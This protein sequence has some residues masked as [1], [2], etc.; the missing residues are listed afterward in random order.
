MTMSARV[1][2]KEGHTPILS[3]KGACK[4]FPGVQALDGVD[5]EVYPGEVVALVGENGA[6]KS[7]LMKIFS[8]AYRRDAGEILLR[9]QPF[10]PD[11]PLAARLAGISVIHQELT[12]CPDMS[13][14]EN[15]FLGREAVQRTPLVPRII[16][17]LAKREETVEADRLLREVGLAIASD[18]KMADLSVSTWQRIEIARAIS[19][20]AELIIMDEPT[21]SLTQEEVKS[22]FGIIRDLRAKGHGVVF[23]THR[24]EEIFDVADRVV[25]LRDGKFVGEL[26]IAE[27]AVPRLVSMMVG[28]EIAAPAPREQAV[29]GDVALEVR[30]LRRGSVVQ[31]VSFQVRRGEVLGV[32]GLMGAGRTEAMRLVFGAD[33]RQSGEILVEGKQVD[34]K[35]P[36]DALRAGITMIPEERKLQALILIQSVT[37]NIALP[38]FSRLATG[39]LAST[40]RERDL[41][42]KYVQLLSI[43]TPSLAQQTQHL[44]GGNQ[45]KVVIARWLAANAKVMIMDEPTRGV[46]VGAKAEIH[47]LIRQIAEQGVAIILVSSEL[48]EILALSDRILVMA[49]GEVTGELSRSQAD[50][51]TIMSLAVP[52]GARRA[53]ASEP[54]HTAAETAMLDAPTQKEDSGF[55]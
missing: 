51:H 26:P 10:N 18:A 1:Q 36:R 19:V 7:T 27:A 33:K 42:Q 35:S 37:F 22:L 53:M 12:V 25:V 47:Q 21:A 39:P 6:G 13:V 4:A 29:G 38:H 40:R 45:Q 44:S 50:Q 14:A 16:R 54:S 48:P 5:F 46:D 32:A 55:G 11:G 8:G 41:A 49:A 24:L 20:D 28:R 34:I 17:P 9:G 2:E 3:A 15:L 52:K 31:D 43:R 23:I 30:N